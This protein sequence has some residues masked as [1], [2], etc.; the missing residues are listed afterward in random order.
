MPYNY[1][2]ISGGSPSPSVVKPIAEYSQP[3]PVYKPQPIAEYSH[4]RPSYPDS[5]K[6]IASH[7][8][9]YN[10]SP[11]K[12]QEVGASVIE[13]AEAEYMVRASGYLQNKNEWYCLNDST[14][15]K[16]NEYK[17][18]RTAGKSYLYLYYK[19]P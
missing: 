2:P 10:S 8:S 19:I 17:A 16:S 11:I 6:P 15:S 13:M 18:L 7:N 14:V 12:H 4:N 1:K 5:I 9:G 3:T